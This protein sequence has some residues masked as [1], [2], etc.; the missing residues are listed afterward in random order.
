[1]N[2]F[3]IGVFVLIATFFLAAA[4]STVHAQGL[5]IR[6][7]LYNESLE[8]GKTKK[9]FVDISNPAD[10]SV[11][12]DLS[13]EGFKQI[14]DKGNL[15]FFRSPDLEKGILL[16]LSEV[17]LK[18]KE[19][20][21]V[22]FLIDGSKLSAG[23]VLAT[24]FA[25]T[26]SDTVGAIGTSARVGTLLVLK[27]GTGGDPSLA[28]TNFSPPFFIISQDISG[29]FQL[30]NTDTS[31]VATGF[32]PHISLELGPVAPIKQTSVGPLV[33]SGITR[34]IPFYITTSRIGFYKLSIVTDG[35]THVSQ[36]VFVITGWWR[37]V[38]TAIA[39][40]VAIFVA[41][42]MYIKKR[43]RPRM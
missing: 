30:K 26:K 31:A 3:R 15:Q 36:W 41:M 4:P 5:Q 33:T 14:D 6:P 2:V 25:S 43:R 10:M 11:T 16:D 20:I 40:I 32:F 39:S 29:S 1:M 42:V 13:V 35:N 7:L 17:S 23:D 8:T 34:T 19:A 27:N 38:A 24:I 18:P 28:I 22:Y 12:V 37:W 9:G 21:R